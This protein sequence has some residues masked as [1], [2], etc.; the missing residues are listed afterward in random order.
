MNTVVPQCNTQVHLIVS[1]YAYCSRIDL[2]MGPLLQIHWFS[3]LYTWHPFAQK[4]II[5]FFPLSS[6]GNTLLSKCPLWNSHHSEVL[7]LSLSV[8]VP[9]LFILRLKKVSSAILIQYT[10]CHIQ[11]VSPHSLLAFR[12]VCALKNSLV[13]IRRPG[14]K[15]TEWLGPNHQP[16]LIPR[17]SNTDGLSRLVLVLRTN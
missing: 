3:G 6:E 1:L 11:R 13:F 9:A 12:S 5:C 14:G 2:R 15:Q 7:L 16:V 17:P 8:I 10:F 4:A